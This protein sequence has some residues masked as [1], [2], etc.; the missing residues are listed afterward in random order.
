MINAILLLVALTITPTYPEP[1]EHKSDGPAP[2]A[3]HPSAGTRT[4]PNANPCGCKL[5][6]GS[7]R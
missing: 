4:T 1:R 5:N 3:V 6:N 2:S 7:H